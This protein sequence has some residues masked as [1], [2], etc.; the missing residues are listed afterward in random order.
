MNK[1]KIKNAVNSMSEDISNQNPKGAQKTANNLINDLG[2]E[3]GILE[4]TT[5][6]KRLNLYNCKSCGNTIVTEDKDKGVTPMFLPCE[7]FRGCD[8]GR[9]VSMMYNVPPILVAG[10]E[11]YLKNPNDETLD[12]RRITEI[13]DPNEALKVMQNRI[14]AET[15]LEKLDFSEPNRKKSGFGKSGATSLHLKHR[16][17]KRK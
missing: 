1:N 4:R 14:A 6:E 2:V 5:G 13:R 11:W 12:I 8:G 15:V 3:T 9:M 10:Y 17:G 7:M 16:K